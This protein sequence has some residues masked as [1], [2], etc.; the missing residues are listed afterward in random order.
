MEPW[1]RPAS[2]ICGPARLGSAKAPSGWFPKNEVGWNRYG[3][4]PLLAKL[5]A[6]EA[7]PE[8]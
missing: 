5:G 7:A 8:P 2:C 1:L 6:S 4:I 3:S